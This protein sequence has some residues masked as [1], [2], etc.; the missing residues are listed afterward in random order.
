MDLTHLHLLLNH[1]PTVGMVI[2]LGIYLLALMTN[3][4]DLKRAGL[5]VFT[6][7]ALIAL[8]TYMTGNSAAEKI[9]NL[10]GVSKSL[11]ASH[12]GMALASLVF[13]ELTGV[14]AWLAL[15]QWRRQA[16][17]SMFYTAAVLLL[18]VVTFA[19]MAQTA[20]IGGEIR[21]PEIVAKD[22]PETTT[23]IGPLARNIGVGITNIPW[24]WAALETIHFIGLTLLMGVILVVDLRLLGVIRGVR[25]ATMHRMLPWAMLGFLVNTASGMAFFVAASGQYDTNPVMGWKVALILLAGA[26]A[27]Y[28]TV[29]D[30]AWML[31]GDEEA[32][33]MDKCIAASAI[34]L[35]IGVIYCGSMLPFIGNAF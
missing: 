16:R 15:W 5:I 3:S 29:F 34:A 22:L 7:I 20:N 30:S 26:N 32:G 11:I 17:I 27:L 10:P 12:E 33:F 13:M 18:G 14:F 4:A 23:M 19:M 28:F 9:Q 24:L 2:A 31:K 6:G 1:F 35:W 25:F 8:P 21:H